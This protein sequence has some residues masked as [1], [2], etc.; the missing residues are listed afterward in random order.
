MG[1]MASSTSRFLYNS[2]MLPYFAWCDLCNFHLESTTTSSGPFCC[3]LSVKKKRKLQVCGT[4]LSEWDVWEDLCKR[5]TLAR[6]AGR[7]PSALHNSKLPAEV[8]APSEQFFS[9]AQHLLNCTFLLLLA[10]T[11]SQQAVLQL[12][13][14]LCP[15]SISL[16]F[17]LRP[18]GRQILPS[19][20][21][22]RVNT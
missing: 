14:F 5:T 18:A 22:R 11:W 10:G 19:L 7:H 15:Y 17:A 21:D 2:M 16:L 4:R 3:R 1:P 9:S 6:C 20:N 8:S 13:V 12:H